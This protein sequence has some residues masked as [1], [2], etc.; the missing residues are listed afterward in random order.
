MLSS[1]YYLDFRFQLCI[2][3]IEVKTLIVIIHI[4]VPHYYYNVLE[5]YVHV[6]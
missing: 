2:N 1:T 5:A 6:Y 3:F 4:G